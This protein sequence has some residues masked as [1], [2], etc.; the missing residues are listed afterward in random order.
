[1]TRKRFRLA[2]TATKTSVC[3]AV[4]GALMLCACESSQLFGASGRRARMPDEQLQAVLKQDFPVGSTRGEVR[5]KAEE[6]G[7]TAAAAS[8]IEDDEGGM[9]DDDEVYTFSFDPGSGWGV[10]R[11]VRVRYGGDGRVERTMLE[12]VFGKALEQEPVR[13]WIHMEGAP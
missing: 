7:M 5:A 9:H 10:T 4:A 1:M 3:A 6:L 8:P 11:A 2:G 13:G 12:P